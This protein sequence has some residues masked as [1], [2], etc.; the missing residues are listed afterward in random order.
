MMIGARQGS[1]SGLRRIIAAAMARDLCAFVV[2]GLDIARARGLNP[3]AAGLHL[4]ATPRHAN[5]LLIIGKLPPGLADAAAV[6]YAQM[7]RPRAI[8]A[9]GAGDIAPL[10][11]ADVTGELSQAGLASALADL[12]PLFAGGAFAPMVTK[13]EASVLQIRIEY[14]CPMHPEV[15]S[16]EPGS[17]PICGM[18]LVP[19]ETSANAHAGH[20]EHDSHAGPAKETAMPAHTPAKPAASHDPVKHSGHDHGKHA[21]APAQYTCPMHPEVISDEPG[22]CPKCGMFLVP[23]ED[24]KHDEHGHAGH[25][26]GKHAAAPAQYTCPMHPE[27]VSDEPGSCP[28]CGMTLVPV[29]DDKH[30]EH[31]HGDHGH[32]SHAGHDHGKHAAA[33]VQYTCPMHPE[34]LSDEPGSCP[35][36]GMTLVPVEDN[37]HGGHGHGG[38]DH[39]KH[40]AAPAQYTCP[41]HPEVLS[42]EP[43]SCPKCGMTLVPVEDNKHGGHGH[44]GHDH[45]KH[46]AAPAQYTCPMHPEVISDEPGSC[47][48]CGM[49]LVPVEDDKYDEHGHGGHDHGKHAAAPAQYT[50]PMH[51]EVISD[52]PGSCPKCGMTLVPVDDKKDGESG[53]GGHGGHG[54][55]GDHDHGK[56]AAAPAQ[57]TC[58]MHPEVLSDE[59]GSCPKCGMTLVPVEDNKH[60]GHGH[61]GHDHGKHAAAPV[62]YTCPMHP[63]VVSDEPGSCPKCGMTLVPV[64]DNKHDEHGHGGHDHG[65]HAAAPAQYTCPMHPEV[66]SDEPGSCPK[67]GMTLVPVDDAKGGAHDHGGHS[68]HGGQDHSMHNGHGGGET[69]PGIEPHFMSMVGLTRDML[70]SPDGLRMD[71]IE[72]PFGPFFPGLPAGL[73]LNLTLDGDTVVETRVRSLLGAGPALADMADASDLCDA[74]AAL[75]PLAPVAMREL[76]C[77]ALESA[78][79][80]QVTPD[81]AAA[82]AVA[83]ERERIVSHLG[84]LAGFAGQTG[85]VWLERRAAALQLALR[86]L[87]ADEIARRAGSVRALLRR[88][89]A[90]PLM[91]AKLAGIGHLDGDASVGGPVAR[92]SGRKKDARAGD[93]VY[94]A[95][96]FA[97]VTQTGG[98]AL[99]RLRQRCDEIAQSL[100]LIASAGEIAIPVSPDIGT[101]SG[102]GT[103]EIETPRGPAQLDLTLEAGRIASAKITTP[104]AAQIDLIDRLTAQT[105]LADALTAIGSLDLDP[106]EVQA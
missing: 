87:P 34:V 12:R 5:V 101:I 36:C 95:L 15:V 78:A 88:V 54:S 62:Q 51:P 13:F 38:H 31:G 30:D 33:P 10:P 16:D 84:W 91:K 60:G 3:A 74:L 6:A 97:I 94:T 41:M 57:Y 77:R 63:E 65:K 89:R 11:A 68:A 98:D 7:P 83:V 69:V 67:C 40:A 47:P 50:C 37:K 53:H 75:V 42:D 21:A 73:D 96:G 8:L 85:M 58:P 106:W 26:H 64:E 105:E 20:G 9:L 103:A 104:F 48:K 66:L 86:D 99:A 102:Q 25:D 70:A 46:A 1:M 45:G 93:P 55:H 23:V 2:P 35:K 17:C 18:T 82:R 24:N 76:A 4:A 43:G 27:V 80:G 49:F 29:E 100:D 52:E 19:R 56:H 90:T 61:G 59:P 22:S 79:G 32:G 81:A 71:W 14:T 44:G 72:V 39:G 92:A 28:K